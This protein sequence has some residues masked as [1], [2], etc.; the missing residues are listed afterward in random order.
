MNVGFDWRIEPLAVVEYLD[1]RRSFTKLRVV[2]S[3]LGG[4]QLLRPVCRWLCRTGIER[5]GF[6]VEPA[7]RL[8]S[9]RPV[10]HDWLCRVPCEGVRRAAEPP[11][12]VSN[13]AV[14]VHGPVLE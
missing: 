11:V 13:S 10:V 6:T 3:D 9:F 1:A 4:Q 7:D 12:L 2:E 8:P 14:G 5:R